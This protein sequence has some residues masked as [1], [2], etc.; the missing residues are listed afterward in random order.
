[1]GPL[2]L[3]LLLASAA[4]AS[5][6]ADLASL[7][8]D[9]WTPEA[10]VYRSAGPAVVSIDVYAPIQRR[11]NF[12]E[13]RTEVARVGQG[14]GVVIDPSGLVITNAHVA[15]PLEFGTRTDDIECR[16]S[17]ADDFG[18]DVYAT[19]IL[20][21]DRE[22]DLALLK[23][24]APGPFYAIPLGRSDDLIPGEKLITIGT[25]YGN[26]HSITS[27][28]LSGVQRNVTV[29]TPLGSKTLAGLIQTDAAINPGNSGGPL[30]NIDGELIGINS[31]TMLSADGIGFAIPVDRVRE[32]LGERLLDVDHSPRFWAGMTVRETEA[33]LAVTALHPRGPAKLAG[34]QV[35]DRI[36]RVDGVPVASLQDYASQLLPH[37]SG[38]RVELR[39]AR[40]IGNRTVELDVPL[41]PARTRETFGLLGFD[42]VRDSVVWR[43]GNR[44]S[45]MP[46]LRVTRV[47]EDS[48]A[49]R[50]G[51]EVGDMIVAA[52]LRN[53]SEGE[54]WQPVR[55]LSELVSLVRGPNF[56]FDEENIWIIRGESSFRGRL[57]FDDPEIVART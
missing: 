54:D 51:L 36:L 33:G 50:L 16:V 39:L 3:P 2:L 49:E 52:R 23:I 45:R 7:Y 43:R 20:N 40:G 38:D 24:Q 5:T 6:D 1:M 17:F 56:E 22:W 4:Q 8:G 12:W 10:Q 27:G 19:Q 55:T 28:I 53:P 11:I 37:K 47:H 26:S 32:I 48:G 25:P 9:R 42:A 14:T 31:A 46:V 29:E 44:R 41:L 18:G 21:M 30:L 34:A 15:V 35:G 57:V 13:T